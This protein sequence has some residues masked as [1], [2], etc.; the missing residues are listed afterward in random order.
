MIWIITPV[1]KKSKQN[2]QNEQTNTAACSFHIFALEI[3][4]V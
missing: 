2:T 3:I 4:F 1:L